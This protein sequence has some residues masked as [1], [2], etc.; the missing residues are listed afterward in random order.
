MAPLIEDFGYDWHHYS[1]SKQFR[2]NIVDETLFWRQVAD[3]F[4][5]TVNHPEE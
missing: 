3:D 2:S 4:G 5:L 1:H